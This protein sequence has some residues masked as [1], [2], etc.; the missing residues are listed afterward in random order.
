MQSGLSAEAMLTAW[1]AGAT[2][3]PLDRALTLLWAGGTG[4]GADLALPAR[5]RRLLALHSATFGTQIE[6]LATCP[7]CGAEVEVSLDAAMLAE[8]LAPPLDMSVDVGGRG[9]TLRVMTS[10]DLAAA[11][12]VPPEDMLELL[13]ARLTPG[14]EALDATDAA[15]IDAAIEA[16]AAAAETLCHLSCPDCG[17]TWSEALDIAAH[18]WTEVEAAA[19]RTLSDVAD[20][21]RAYGWTESEVLALS[22]ARRAAYLRLAREWA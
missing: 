3:G 7:D 15:Q 22:P 20:L 16:Q 21:A 10:R 18:L 11:Q 17:A 4:D 9:I 1:E 13:R 8:A 5:D 2:R 12:E 19:M 6:C 14:Y